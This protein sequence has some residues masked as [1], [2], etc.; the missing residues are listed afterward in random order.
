MNLV[1]MVSLLQLQ[2]FNIRFLCT[3]IRLED[4][5]LLPERPQV[6]LADSLILVDLVQLHVESHNVFSSFR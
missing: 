1:N 2:L 5:I 4:A 6:S 3:H